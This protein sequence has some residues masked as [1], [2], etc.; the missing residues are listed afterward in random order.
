LRSKKSKPS[1]TI[2][3]TV[4]VCHPQTLVYILEVGA[5]NSSNKIM[6]WDARCDAKPRHKWKA[7]IATSVSLTPRSDSLPY[8]QIPIDD[9]LLP[10]LLPDG[11]SRVA[12]FI[13]DTLLM[14]HLFVTPSPVG[15]ETYGDDSDNAF[16]DRSNE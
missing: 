15:K 3:A 2:I 10:Q 9:A 14:V 12:V 16:T 4:D 7:T 13:A 11:R 6:K 5:S 1:E 8:R